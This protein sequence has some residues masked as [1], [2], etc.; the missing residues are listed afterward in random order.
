MQ[1]EAGL[2]GASPLFS[3]YCHSCSRRG[4]LASRLC[5]SILSKRL[6]RIPALWTNKVAFFSGGPLNQS[7]TDT[8]REESLQ[9]KALDHYNLHFLH[10]KHRQI[11]FVV[12]ASSGASAEDY[13]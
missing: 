8:D 11:A 9:I 10:F 3:G 5:F 4:T 6:P 12:A 2:L 1:Y 7:T 13:H